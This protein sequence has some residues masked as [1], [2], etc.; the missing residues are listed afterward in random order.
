MKTLILKRYQA[1]ALE[2]VGRYFDKCHEMGDAGFAFE[3]VTEEFWGTRS[4]F[5][6]LEGFDK[7]MPYF[8]LRVPTG[9]GKTFMA[10]KAVSLINSRL[11][12]ADHSLILWLTPSNEIREQTLRALRD[13]EHPYHAALL[14]AGPVTVLELSEAKSITPATL[15]TSTVVIVCTRQAFQVENVEGRKVYEESGD[16]MAHFSALTGTQ[17]ALLECDEGRPLYSFMNVMRLRRPF[18]I[19]DEAHNSRTALGFDTLARFRPSGIMELTATPDMEKE[20]S[21][22]LHSVHAGELKQDE[23]IKLPI[24]LETDSNWQHCLGLAIS[25]RGQLGA[26]AFHEEREHGAPYL[27]PIVLIQAEKRREGVETRDASAVKRELMENQGIPEAEIA[28]ATGE[29]RELANVAKDYPGGILSKSCPINYV[30]TQQ[31]LAEGWD[32]PFAYILVSLMEL[33]SS[34]KVEQLL[35]RILR[36]PGAKRR[37]SVELNRAYAFVVSRD[38]FDTAQALRDQ[39]VTGA[40]FE[41]KEANEFVAAQKSN[42]D[43]WD[44]GRYAGRVQFTPIVIPLPEKLDLRALPKEI[45]DKVTWDRTNQA[46]ML[47][48][49]VSEVDEEAL[50]NLAVM[51]GTRNQIKAGI[52]KAR[53]TV[54]IF[55]AP[56]ER[57]LRF[58]VPQLNVLVNGEFTLFDEPEVLEYP[59]ELPL[60]EAAPTE[61]QLATLRAQTAA[62]D[63]AKLDVTEKEGHVTLNYLKDLQRELVLTYKPE[64]WDEARLECWICCNVVDF[65]VDHARKLAFVA[66]WIGE[67]LR[68]DDFDLEFVNRE[69]FL[70]R[71]L[72]KKQIDALHSAAAKSAYQQFLFSDDYAE[73][74][75]TG[76]EN[77]F[78]FNPDMYCPARDYDGR[79]GNQSFEKHYYARVGDFDSKEEFECA[80]WLDVHA[81][82]GRVEFWVRNLVRRPESFWLPTETNRFYPDFVCKLPSG[83]IL[84]VEYKGGD[85]WT[86]AEGDRRIGN[87]WAE[88]SGGRCRFV[89]VKDRRWTDI[90]PLLH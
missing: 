50:K 65:S 80:C 23:M 36:Q 12:R 40:G 72:L 19:V 34:T 15:D 78:L 10:A 38:F 82:L 44:F 75:K 3:A 37:D 24:L 89:M 29:M 25:L 20:P 11:L 60:A 85:R 54:R 8:C 17:K 87:L 52:E 9:G 32:C 79:Y 35:G 33:R 66:G 45:R 5:N 62:S 76:G 47:N 2:S 58:E 49:P 70:I 6:S 53:E 55:H 48:E 90:E 88:L 64:H 81:Q 7:K 22:V 63:T 4:R 83:V 61:E 1:A 86:E 18:L 56:A 84:V 74:V 26:L 69:K 21:N 42:Q 31:A 67:L 46:L 41:R 14:D 13:K 16:L 51:E 57:G 39:L 30:I 27:R 59:W 68:R 43:S 28:I 73:R 71:D 77:N